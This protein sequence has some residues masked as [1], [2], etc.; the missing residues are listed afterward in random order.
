MINA[1]DLD[2]ALVAM[3]AE[4]FVELNPMTDLAHKTAQLVTELAQS[5]LGKSIV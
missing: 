4:D 5:A 1:Q 2:G 3:V